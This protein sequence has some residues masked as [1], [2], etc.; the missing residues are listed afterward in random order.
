MLG[1]GEPSQPSGGS[2]CPSLGM[3]SGS[4]REAMSSVRGSPKPR[5]SASP[6]APDNHGPP[7]GPPPQAPCRGHSAA[8]RRGGRAELAFLFTFSDFKKVKHQSRTSLKTNSLTGYK[9]R[10]S[11]V[12]HPPIDLAVSTALGPSLPERLNPCGRQ[13][14]VPSESRPQ[15]PVH[16]F[17]SG[18]ISVLPIP[19]WPAWGA[20]PGLDVGDGIPGTSGQ[21]VRV[22][23]KLA[24]G[25]DPGV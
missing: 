15:A 14:P 7:A 23:R 18:T 16:G 12:C 8:A 4:H 2:R 21:H 6:P 24:A 1:W 3:G 13:R 9:V 20:S 22:S 25:L 19:S 17:L 10:R 11:C 5:G